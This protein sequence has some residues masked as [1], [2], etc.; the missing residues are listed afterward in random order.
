VTGTKAWKPVQVYDLSTLCSAPPTTASQIASMS[1]VYSAS[2]IPKTTEPTKCI[3]DATHDKLDGIEVV[4]GITSQ[5]ST[6]TGTISTTGSGADCGWTTTANLKG[7]NEPNG[8]YAKAKLKSKQ[9]CLLTISGFTWPFGTIDN[10]IITNVAIRVVHAEEKT[11]QAATVQINSAGGLV[12]CSPITVVPPTSA[13]KDTFIT[14]SKVL[15]T[16]CAPNTKTKMDSISVVY[17]AWCTPPG[18]SNCQDSDREH[19]VDAIV[20]DFTYAVGDGNS[21]IVEFCATIN[22]ADCNSAGTTRSLD[23]SVQLDGATNP[24]PAVLDWELAR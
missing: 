17:T 12:T 14:F 23:A 6:S 21:R 24:S 3:S 11:T 4:A 8:T 1:I 10:P 20:F 18:P 5:P 7:A 13:N 15:D 19:R 9:T 16:S 22:G 2:C